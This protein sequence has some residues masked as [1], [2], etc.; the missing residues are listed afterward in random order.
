MT[1]LPNL[2]VL[3]TKHTLY[4]AMRIFNIFNFNYLSYDWTVKDD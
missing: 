4:A 3:K 2:K 1:S